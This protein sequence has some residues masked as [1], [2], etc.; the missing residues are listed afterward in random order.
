MA[1]KE[2]LK[3]QFEEAFDDTEQKE[4]AAR[5]LTTQTDAALVVWGDREAVIATGIRIKTMLP[6]G[7][8]LTIPHALA[9]G[10]YAVATGLNPFRGEFYA[11]TDKKGNLSIVDGYKALTRWAED[12]CPF[13]VQ[14]RPL[15]PGPGEAYRIK[16][17]IMRHD[18]KKQLDYY[19]DKGADFQT[20]FDLVTTSA[21]GV[22]TED[23]TR[24]ADSGK[25]KDPPT[26]WTWEQRAETRALKNAL[27]RSHKM[28]TVAELAR[29]SWEVAGIMT[30][31]EDWEGTEELT[32]GE[33]RERLAEMQ[34]RDRERQ[35]EWA[36]L[37]E[38]EKK[39]K[40]QDASVMLYGEDT[41]DPFGEVI[42]GEVSHV[43]TL[44]E[45]LD[46]PL[47]REAPKTGLVK[48]DTLAEAVKKD[49]KDLVEYLTKTSSY[50]EPTGENER[51]RRAA[52]I[53]VES[54]DEARSIVNPKEEVVVVEG[55]DSLF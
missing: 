38:E 55:Q 20:A 50:S 37:S 24:W 17:I 45:A 36:T 53:I 15:D 22:V 49:A 16:C 21:V 4:A 7:D 28:P 31:S 51:L 6:G 46:V 54:W 23:E 3:Q 8:K 18:R 26:G 14:Y 41:D 30:R 43:M 48:G 33:E 52:N 34:A 29:K 27:N 2:E 5:A 13:D 47:N 11:Y 12:E 40:V 9:A 42:E 1:T 39:E 25:A 44:R 19:L 32:T 10:Q 35:E